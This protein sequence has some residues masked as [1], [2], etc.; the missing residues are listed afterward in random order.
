MNLKHALQRLK[1]T[2]KFP[3]EA[4]GKEIGMI[5]DMHNQEIDKK[6]E[7]QYG[8]EITA[9]NEYFLPLI[10]HAIDYGPAEK[11]RGA[12]GY[13]SAFKKGEER[14]GKNFWL[15]ETAKLEA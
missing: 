8:K 15:P 4:T 3:P 1:E 2:G 10:K 11:Y 5:L 14:F 9:R 7:K 12:T 6:N 13:G